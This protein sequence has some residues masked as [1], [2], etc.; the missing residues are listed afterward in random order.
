MQINLRLLCDWPFHLYNQHFLFRWVIYSC[1]YIDGSYG[2]ILRR[3]Q[4]WCSFSLKV[5]LSQPCSNF[6]VWYF[7]CLSLEVSIELFSFTF[8]FSGYFFSIYDC[9]FCIV[10]MASN[11]CI[12]ISTLFWMLSSHLPPFLDTYSLNVSPLRC[13]ALCI[14]NKFS[15]SLFHLFKFFPRPHQNWSRVSFKEKSLGVYPFD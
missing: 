11:C 6:L 9:V 2:L 4:K 1:F 8:L 7:L 15:Y 3:F 12:D 10:L 13:K 5:S 14:V